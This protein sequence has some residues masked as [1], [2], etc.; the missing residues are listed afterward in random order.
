MKQ[1]VWSVNF[2]PLCSASMSLIVF[3]Y[4]LFPLQ[5]LKGNDET[6]DE[7]SNFSTD[8]PPVS[9]E[10]VD[11]VDRDENMSHQSPSTDEGHLVSVSE[12]FLISGAGVV[13]F[14]ALHNHLKRLFSFSFRVNLEQMMKQM[15][16]VILQLFLSQSPI[17]KTFKMLWSN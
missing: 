7:S 12:F 1:T 14:H 4:Y 3:I 11:V 5:D 15:K 10:L 6:S 16:K 13:A 9:D 8:P 17:W 2:F